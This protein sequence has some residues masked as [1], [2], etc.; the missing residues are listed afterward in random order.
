MAASMQ[1]HL[2]AGDGG[3]IPAMIGLVL[4]PISFFTQTTLVQ[5]VSPYAGHEFRG[6]GDSG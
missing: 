2:N 4:L 5:V 6:R 3:F 1:G